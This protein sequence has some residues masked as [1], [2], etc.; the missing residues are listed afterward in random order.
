MAPSSVGN[1][2]RSS[3]ET[4]LSRL[5]KGCIGVEHRL[6][7]D[8][9]A[10]ALDQ[11]HHLQKGQQ[12]HMTAIS[13]PNEGLFGGFESLTFDD[14]LVVPG[15][16]DVLPA[17]VSTIEHFDRRRSISPSRCCRPQWTPSPR[18]RS[19]SPSP[20]EG[21]IGD[22][23]PEPVDSSNRLQEVDR[24]KRSQAGMITGAGQSRAYCHPRRRRGHHV[25]PQHLRCADHR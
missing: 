1:R 24:V 11:P 15:W 12:H 14:V 17:E 5:R 4:H 21:G 2:F 23:S 19:P 10:S 7:V 16:S 22:P 8:C 3:P 18:H 13:Q 6:L 20:A 25:A 9:I